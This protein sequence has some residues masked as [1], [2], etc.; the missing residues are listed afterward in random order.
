MTTMSL[1]LEDQQ[2]RALNALAMAEGTSVSEVIRSA[3]A[4]R[5]EKRRGD[6]DFQQ[7]LKQAVERNKEALDLLAK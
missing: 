2:A 5:I 6:K 1:R 7:K 4:D 3:I